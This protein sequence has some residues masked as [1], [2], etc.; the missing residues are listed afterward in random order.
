MRHHVRL[1]VATWAVLLLLLGGTWG[2]AMLPL[3]ETWSVVC[4]M[5]FAAAKTAIVAWLFMHLNESTGLTRVAAI[6][7]IPFLFSLGLVTLLD[8]L[9]R[10]P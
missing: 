3:N 8:V 5:G 2:A 4:N 9:F 6:A 7:A 10:V 1:F